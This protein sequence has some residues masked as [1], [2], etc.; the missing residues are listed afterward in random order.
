[1]G[2]V[3]LLGGGIRPSPLGYACGCSVLD[4]EIRPGVTVLASWA[5]RWRAT[6][7]DGAPPPVRCLVARGAQA[8]TATHSDEG[9]QIAV[10]LDPREFCGPAGAVRDAVANLG[11]DAVIVVHEAAAFPTFDPGAVVAAHLESDAQGTVCV[12]P[13]GAA[14]GFFVFRAGDFRAVSRVGF[15]DLKEQF[16]TRLQA[17]GARIRAHR[18]PDE[19]LLPLRTR[20]GFLHAAMFAA[21]FREDDAHG[22][23]PTILSAAQPIC[24]R[25]IIAGTARVSS[26][27]AVVR[28][29][30]M[31]GSSVDDGAV[32]VRSIVCSGASVGAGQEVLDAVV[33]REGVRTDAWAEAR[34]RWRRKSS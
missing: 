6:D 4:L 8:P 29:V 33:S 15:T 10:E 13:D 14:A 32:V 27:A 5:R 2:A 11:D 1:M 34:A 16:L 20:A 3:L 23:A 21:G 31:S 22:L 30:I 26:R 17:A 28:S 12:N 9:A 7:L 24:P 25:S 18:L 19:G